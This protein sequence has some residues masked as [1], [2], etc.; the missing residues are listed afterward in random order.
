MKIPILILII[1]LAGCNTKSTES[2]NYKIIDCVLPNIPYGAPI[3]KTKLRIDQDGYI[4]EI[5]IIQS[6]GISEIDLSITRVLETCKVDIKEVKSDKWIDKTFT[7]T[8]N[9]A[10]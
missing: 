7:W 10:K 5:K 1:L 4:R 3:V 8:E 9:I 6:S 2:I